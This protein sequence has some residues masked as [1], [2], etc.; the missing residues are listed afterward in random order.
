[1]SDGMLNNEVP[2]SGIAK[3]YLE[4]YCCKIELSSVISLNYRAQA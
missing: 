4:E 1:M 3:A 2:V